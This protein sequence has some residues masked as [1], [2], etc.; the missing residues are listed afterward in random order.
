MDH[1]LRTG[2]ALVGDIGRRLIT[3]LCCLSLVA[4]A[5]RRAEPKEHPIRLASAVRAI[6]SPMIDDGDGPPVPVGGAEP[7]V[8]YPWPGLWRDIR[9][10]FRDHPFMSWLVVV[11][12]G[13]F[14]GSLAIGHGPKATGHVGGDP[15]ANQQP[16]GRYSPGTPCLSTPIPPIATRPATILKLHC[17]EN[18]VIRR[19][20][21]ED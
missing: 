20:D 21:D 16:G 7:Q 3:G 5:V 15:C 18:G 1:P 8:G 11:S 13:I 4:C 19:C 10:G 14:I 12:A 9:A 2:S 6:G 17:G